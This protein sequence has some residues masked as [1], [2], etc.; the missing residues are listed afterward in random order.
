MFA[1]RWFDRMEQGRNY[2]GTPFF[3]GGDRG[4]QP[5]IPQ[6]ISYDFLRELQKVTGTPRLLQ[7]FFL[8]LA[9]LCQVCIKL[10]IG[11]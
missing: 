4:P 1:F 8:L 7:L 3:L 2:N 10:G 6:N 5:P 9:S 11:S